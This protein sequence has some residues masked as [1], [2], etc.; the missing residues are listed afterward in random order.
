MTV[1]IAVSNIGSFLDV[2]GVVVY[3]PDSWNDL[4]V[5]W[6]FSPFNQPAHEFLSYLQSRSVS[7]ALPGAGRLALSYWLLFYGLIVASDV[8]FFVLFPIVGH[9]TPV[10]FFLLDAPI[11]LVCRPISRHKQPTIYGRPDPPGSRLSQPLFRSF[12]GE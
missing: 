1:G 2:F 10:A 4:L 11:S 7:G 9:L 8:F 6:H 3:T 5:C 12:R